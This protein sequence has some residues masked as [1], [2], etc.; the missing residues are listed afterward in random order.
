M[1]TPL[2]HI[3]LHQPDCK[4]IYSHRL[5]KNINGIINL[6]TIKENKKVGKK[7]EKCLKKK[8]YICIFTNFDN[9]KQLFSKHFLA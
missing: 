7:K 4:Y 8:K 9:K 5:T 2:G 3:L 6:N 1:L